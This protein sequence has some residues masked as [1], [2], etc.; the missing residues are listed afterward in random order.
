MRPLR[1]S[2]KAGS[3]ASGRTA[4]RLR[5]R[6]TQRRGAR[7]TA[8]RWTAGAKR[9]GPGGPGGRG[10]PGLW[11]SAPGSRAPPPRRRSLSRR[12]GPCGQPRLRARLAVLS[13]RC[14]RPAGPDASLAFWRPPASPAGWDAEAGFQHERGRWSNEGSTGAVR[15]APHRPIALSRVPACIPRQRAWLLG[16]CQQSARSAKNYEIP[17]TL[18]PGGRARLPTG[19]AG[20]SSTGRWTARSATSKVCDRPR[21]P[22]P[23]SH[24]R[25]RITRGFLTPPVNVDA[26]CDKKFGVAN[27]ISSTFGKNVRHFCGRCGGGALRPRGCWPPARRPATDVGVAAAG[28]R[29][30]EPPPTCLPSAQRSARST[31]PTAPTGRRALAASPRSAAAS[32]AS[33][34][35][36]LAPS[37]GAPPPPAGPRKDPL[38]R[39]PGL[40][41]TAR[42]GG[43]PPPAQ[44]CD[45]RFEKH[46]HAEWAREHKSQETRCNAK[47]FS[48]PTEGWYQAVVTEKMKGGSGSGRTAAAAAAPTRATSSGA[49]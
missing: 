35:P 17:L 24:D 19:Q 7:A 9:G 34:R 15:P 13:S 49:E 28:R 47:K 4:A 6:C 40:L 44:I 8:R 48:L 30:A 45:I 27:A 10:G 23:W 21:A 38:P 46:Y 32:C 14:A 3:R 22:P 20:G 33:P 39:P 1:R 26:G 16:S 25:S 37:R 12:S 41:L 11:D 5:R 31:P 18:P 42:G 29:E 2:P 43:A 36:T